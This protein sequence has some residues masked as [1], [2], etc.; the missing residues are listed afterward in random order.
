MTVSGSLADGTAERACYVLWLNLIWKL[1]GWWLVRYAD[2]VVEA[3]VKKVIEVFKN[4][5][6]RGVGEQVDE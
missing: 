6:N 1:G 5:S 4:F 3:T 2:D